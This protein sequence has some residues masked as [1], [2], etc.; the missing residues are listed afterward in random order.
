MKY[1]IKRTSIT[2]SMGTFNLFK[3]ISMLAIVLGHT[4]G[5]TNLITSY[6]RQFINAIGQSFVVCLFICCGFGI[7]SS[8]VKTAF[9]TQKRSYFKLYLIVTCITTVLYFVFNYL[10]NTNFMRARNETL[11]ILGGFITG[12]S[13]ITHLLDWTMY[14]GGLMW[15]FTTLAIS[16]FLLSVIL[17][18]ADEKKQIYI[19]ILSMII[20]VYLSLYWKHLPFCLI[21]SMICLFFMYVG[22]F[23]KKKKV[24]E[25]NLP[26]WTLLFFVVSFISIFPDIGI[27]DNIY[28]YGIISVLGTTVVAY[29][30]IYWYLRIKHKSGK[31]NDFINKVGFDSSYILCIHAVEYSAIPWYVVVDKYQANPII[32]TIIILITR[33][34][35]IVLSLAVIKKVKSRRF[36]IKKREKKRY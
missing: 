15:F 10:V 24:L 23:V 36:V 3:G 9:K 31:I 14:D 26:W 22:Y 13:H 4:I 20:G 11:M 7:R 29:F 34:I 1:L 35:I 8:S 17:K 12:E 5:Q 16:G 32:S 25:I 21:Q 19:V 27:A 30:F 33:I 6:A 18:Y 2:Y 28:C